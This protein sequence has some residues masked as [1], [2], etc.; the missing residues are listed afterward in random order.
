MAGLPSWWGVTV[1][2][3]HTPGNRPAITAGTSS[4]RPGLCGSFLT[5]STSRTSSVIKKRRRTY[6]SSL[7]P[8]VPFLQTERQ[9]LTLSAALSASG[10]VISRRVSFLISPLSRATWAWAR[11]RAFSR[12]TFSLV[13]ASCSWE[14]SLPDNGS[15]DAPLLLLNCRWK[16]KC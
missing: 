5:S 13:Q 15:F 14:S 9:G 12:R 4:G 2:L 1:W 6:A 10:P 3:P 16:F 7:M 11:S 8:G